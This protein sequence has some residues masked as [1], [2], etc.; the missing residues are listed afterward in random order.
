MNTL[1]KVLRNTEITVSVII[2]SY[3]SENSI[4]TTLHSIK[5]QSY[6][7]YEC[8]IIDD[9]SNDRTVS[10][11]HEFIKDDDRFSV[12]LRKGSKKGANTCRN[13]GLNLSTGEFIVFLDADDFL[14]E[15]CLEIRSKKMLENPTINLGIFNTIVLRKRKM[16]FT[17]YSFNPLKGFL[18]GS[19]PWQTMSPIWKRSY[20][21]S[22]EGFDQD[23]PRLQDVELHARA[24]LQDDITYKYFLFTKVDSFY[25]IN[26]N[27]D[28]NISKDKSSKQIIG[29][30][31]YL[32]KMLPILKT[33]KQRNYLKRM[34]YMLLLEVSDNAV[35]STLETKIFEL[36]KKMKF[37]Y[38]E[39]TKINFFLKLNDKNILTKKL[40]FEIIFL[41]FSRIKD[42]INK[43]VVSLIHKFI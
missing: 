30:I 22:L 26:Q 9:H 14:A 23:F 8:I 39:T 5:N 2:P 27:F 25:V 21:I 1:N 29:F 7:N 24:L 36:R 11:I 41:H 16:L 6:P 35:D 33:D 32:E 13:E 31:Y 19:Y 12:F 38:L 10:I 4:L 28:K 37:N 42:Y 34:Y 20:L 17:R 43:L 18:S 3:N 40:L 15:H